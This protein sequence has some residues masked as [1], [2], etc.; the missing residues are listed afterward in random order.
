MEVWEERK[1]TPKLSKC[2]VSYGGDIIPGESGSEDQ[3]HSFW[4]ASMLEDKLFS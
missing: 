2:I 3:G 4:R 1:A